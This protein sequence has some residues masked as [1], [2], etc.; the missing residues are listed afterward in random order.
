MAV[1]TAAKGGVVQGVVIEQASARP[2]ERTRVRL[3]PVP[4]AASDARLLMARAGSSGH[5]LFPAVPDGLYLLTAIRDHYFPAS[6]GQRLPSGQGIPFRVTRDSDLFAE[7][8]MRR[9]GAITGRI[10]DENGIGVPGV[11]VV[12]YR[13]RLPLRI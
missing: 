13:T 6:Y 2:M 3:Q 10:L 11:N 4:N 8:R 1:L 12:A 9:M 5:F 7:L